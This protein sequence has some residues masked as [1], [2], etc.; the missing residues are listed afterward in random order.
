MVKTFKEI[1]EIIKKIKNVEEK[2]STGTVIHIIWENK[3]KLMIYSGNVG[4]TKASLVSPE[5]AIKITQDQETPEIKFNKF[6]LKYKKNVKNSFLKNN[7]ELDK[8]KD[9]NNSKIFGNYLIREEEEEK[10]LLYGHKKYYRNKNIIL[11][12]IKNEDSEKKKIYC[13]P[14]IAKMEIDL[15]LKNQFLFLCSDGIWDKFD[16]NEMKQLINNNKD[17]EQL[18]SIIVKNVLRRDSKHNIS[19]F[20]IKLT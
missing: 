18:C 1:D 10:K 20:S 9:N 12:N 8:E 4:N 17:T 11:N 6:R 2:S 3:N 13:V 16:E 5:Y 7:Y 14:Y 19:I 15:S